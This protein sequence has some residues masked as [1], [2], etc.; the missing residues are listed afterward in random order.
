MSERREP[1]ELFTEAA[2]SLYG[3]R[4]VEAIAGALG[5]AQRTIQRWANGSREVPPIM[6]GRLLDLLYEERERLEGT[7]R[8]IMDRQIEMM[9]ERRGRR[10]EGEP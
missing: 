5:V 8:G 7:A 9:E 1:N 4:Y 10:R 3:E 6:W 2:Q